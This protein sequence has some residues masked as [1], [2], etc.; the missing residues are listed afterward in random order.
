MPYCPKCGNDVS[1]QDKFCSKCGI[2]L[3]SKKSTPSAGEITNRSYE[4]TTVED[5]VTQKSKLPNWFRRHLNWTATIGIA[6]LFLLAALGNLRDPVESA[7]TVNSI[8]SF[9]MDVSRGDIGQLGVVLS[10]IGFVA[11][12]TTLGWVLRQKERSLWHLL[13]AL[14]PFG[15][16]AP[17]FLANESKRPINIE[18]FLGSEMVCDSAMPLLAIAKRIHPDDIDVDEGL[19][20]PNWVDVLLFDPLEEYVERPSIR[21]H[22]LLLLWYYTI[23]APFVY[24]SAAILGR[25][26]KEKAYML[27][28]IHRFLH[29]ESPDSNA[30]VAEQVANLRLDEFT[31]TL[32]RE[33]KSFDDFIGVALHVESMKRLGNKLHETKR[34]STSEAVVYLRTLVLEGVG[35]GSKFPD[36]TERMYRQHWEKIDM[37]RW[38]KARKEGHNLP[39]QPTIIPLERT[40]EAILINITPAIQDSCPELMEPLGL[41]PFTYDARRKANLNPFPLSFHERFNMYHCLLGQ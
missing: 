36:L 18:D 15:F 27:Y 24:E 34:V 12:F 23:I 20:H 39:E 5:Y 33:P 11:L 21:P 16:V 29:F 19:K 28:K 17:I 6:V 26:R 14:I 31:D 4:E 8:V 2:S 9:I 40:E 3:S 1:E 32:K 38:R 37:K 22:Y 10:A 41:E 13:L 7:L 25:A 35:F 30:E